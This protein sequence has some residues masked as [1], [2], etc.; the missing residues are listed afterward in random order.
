MR[1][2]AVLI[3][4]VFSMSS[5]AGDCVCS[6]LGSSKRECKESIDE[7]KKMCDAM[8]PAGLNPP[9]SMS[10]QQGVCTGGTPPADGQVRVDGRPTGYWTDTQKDINQGE[11]YTITAPDNGGMWHTNPY[12]SVMGANGHPTNR[13]GPNYLLPGAPEQALI[14]KVGNGPAFLIGSQGQTPP[15]SSGR[16]YLTPNDEPAGFGDNSGWMWV[17][18]KRIAP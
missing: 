5:H 16:L 13:G 8:N 14:G 6:F 4:V 15:N 12:W 18:V 10:W 7:C 3:M 17:S 9:P 1:F 11:V 2:V